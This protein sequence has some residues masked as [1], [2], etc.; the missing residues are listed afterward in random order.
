MKLPRIVLPCIFFLF[1]T[2]SFAQNIDLKSLDTLD[3][4]TAQRIALADNPSLMAAAERVE[5]AKQQ[6]EQV[7]ASYYPTLGIEGAA[8]YNRLSTNYRDAQSLLYGYEVDQNQEQYQLSLVA[9]WLLF[10]GFSRKYSTLAARYGGEETELSRQDGQRLLLQSVAESYFS[11]QLALYNITIAE[12]NMD[13]NQQQLDEAEFKYDNGAGSLSE[14][15][16]FRIQINRAKTSLLTYRRDYQIS[17]HTLAVLLGESDSFPENIKLAEVAMID[18]K[19]F[20]Q[21]DTNE[22]IKT[23]NYFRPDIN[24]SELTVQRAEAAI[25][26]S[27]AAYYPTVSLSGSLDGSRSDDPGLEGDDVAATAALNLQYNLYRGGGDKAGILSAKAAKREAVRLLEMQ[28]LQLAGE[29]RQAYD[30]LQ[31]AQ[32]QLMLQQSTTGLV[33]QT[34]DLVKTSY[35]A[36]QESLVRLNEVQR[37][38]VAT[39]SNLALALVS[40]YRLRYNLKTATGEN[41]LEFYP[42]LATE[43][44]AGE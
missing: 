18:E 39:Q 4:E 2:H 15:L 25:G 13:F 3:L 35:N 37:D 27:E 22:L 24:Q 5:Q 8:A 29:I 10:D 19:Q 7:K 38:V 12:A 16:N 42:E 21:F 26:A 17:L 1:T 20:Y 23:A 43:K 40:L 11:A 30:N 9:G 6:L 36:G 14:V 32:Q 41:L 33:L 44:T 34:R 31:L 28:K